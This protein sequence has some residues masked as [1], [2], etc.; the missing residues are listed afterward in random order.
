[1]TEIE[2]AIVA[3]ITPLLAAAGETAVV[4]TGSGNE[5]LPNDAKAVICSVQSS[6]AIVGPLHKAALKVIVRTPTLGH[7]ITEHRDACAAVRGCFIAGEQANL[8]TALSSTGYTL[9]GWFLSGSTDAHEEDRWLTSIAVTLGV[10]EQEFKA[11]S[12]YL[13]TWNGATNT[14]TLADETGE[15]GQCYIVATAGTQDLGGGSVDYNVGDWLLHNGTTWERV[16]AV[17]AGGAVVS[18]AGKTGV[19]TLD[20]DDIA[21]L[22]TAATKDAGVTNDKVLLIGGGA[23]DDP[24]T[25]LDGGLL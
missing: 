23:V 17:S 7:N 9:G 4:F 6:E 15:G 11:P 3:W 13:G 20:T 5:E 12:V 19:V 8:S 21:G 24:N 25:V 2:P 14:P 18:V 10:R 16:E 1:M 22:G